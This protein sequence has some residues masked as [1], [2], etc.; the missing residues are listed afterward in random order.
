VTHKIGISDV[1]ENTPAYKYFYH[2]AKPVEILTILKVDK[3]SCHML[4]DQKT[5]NIFFCLFISLYKARFLITLF[6]PTLLDFPLF[7]S[8]VF[9]FS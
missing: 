1:Q 5:Q 3:V 9:L 2:T 6:F 7:K 4:K 8:L